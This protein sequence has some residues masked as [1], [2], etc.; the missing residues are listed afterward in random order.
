MTN[1]TFNNS[2]YQTLNIPDLTLK[3][4]DLIQNYCSFMEMEI[5]RILIILIIAYLFIFVV[6]QFKK[7]LG[8]Q[9]EQVYFRIL[10]IPYSFFAGLII[11]NKGFDNEILLNIIFFCFFLLIIV[12][13]A[14]NK[15]VQKL[16]KKAW[17]EAKKN[18]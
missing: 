10:F 18:K 3:E 2:F 7:D 17:L 11:I 12:L 13:L 4:T 8:F 9:L 16:I 6:Y 14:F 15:T 5:F 1:I